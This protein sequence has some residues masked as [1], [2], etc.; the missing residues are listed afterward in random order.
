MDDGRKLKEMQR[1]AELVT[2]SKRTR[3]TACGRAGR[4]A[5]A[6]NRRNEVP[7]WARDVF[8]THYANY[9]I[10]W[11]N[12]ARLSSAR[13]VA[14]AL[15]SPFVKTGQHRPAFF[16]PHLLQVKQDTIAT[17]HAEKNA[18]N[19]PRIIFPTTDFPFFS[20]VVLV[21]LPLFVSPQP[22]PLCADNVVLTRGAEE[23]DS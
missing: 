12:T 7:S 1:Q 10:E 17:N 14:V 2:S 5:D 23:E 6:I 4:W 13:K 22:M 3:K 18:P 19:F 20:F 21:K 11:E 9:M 16:L 8:Q 15:K